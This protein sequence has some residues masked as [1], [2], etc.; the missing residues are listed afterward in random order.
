MNKVKDIDIVAQLADLKNIDYRNT[1][2][3]ATLVELLIDKKIITR[4]EF[5]KKAQHLDKM[6]LDEL[7]Q[8]RAR[9]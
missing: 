9:F 1:L 8:L 6:S 7:R 4:Q 5:A 3:I 2:A